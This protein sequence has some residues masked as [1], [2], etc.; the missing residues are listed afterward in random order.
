M[1]A[2]IGALIDYS[3]HLQVECIEDENLED[4][5]KTK[6]GEEKELDIA[7]VVAQ[8]GNQSS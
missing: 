8:L 2:S 4:E 3:F 7:A 1:H 5:A 6:D